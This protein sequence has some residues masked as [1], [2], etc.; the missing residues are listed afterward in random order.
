VK[1]I[2][3]KFLLILLTGLFVAAGSFYLLRR[4][5]ISRNAGGKLELARKRLDE[6]KVADATSLFAQY[7]ALR[8]RDNEAYAEYSKLLL[9]RALSPDATRNDVA[10]AFNTLEAAVR[11]NPDDDDLR[12]QLAEFQLRVGRGTDAREHLSLLEKRLAEPTPAGSDESPADRQARGRKVRF[13]NATTYL[14][15]G[16][17]EEAAR[18]V[19]EMVGYDLEKRQFRDAAEEVTA[20]TD[21]YVML[22]AILQERM[23]ARADARRVL[24]ELVRRHE[25]DPRAWLAMTSWFR[26]RGDLDQA[27]AAMAKALKLDPDAPECV[28][29]DFELAL[30]AR[31]L[32]RAEATVR[33]AVELFP[34][35]ERSY[36]GLAAVLMQQ[37]DVG[38]AEQALLDG[39]ERLPA[40]ASLQLMLADTLLQQNKLDE[41]AQAITRIRE[42][43]GS[44]SGP[45]GLLEARL[46]VA[47]RRWSEAKAKLEQMRPLLLGNAELVR[48]VDLYLAQ[49]HGQLNEYDAQLEVNRRI[50]TDEPGSL[51]ARA[52]A[53][54]ALVSAGKTAE[55]LEEFEAIASALPEDKLV[56]IP[57]VWYPLFQLRLA[58]QA[59][60]P[61]ADRDWSGVDA[62]L[63]SLAKFATVPPSQLA[64]LRAEALIR[65]GESQAARDLLE[66]TATADADVQVWAA[67]VT[68]AL[69]ADGPDA[70]TA[71]LASV[72]QRLTDDPALMA[73]EARIAASRPAEVARQ[74]L[75]DLEK[76]A[77]NLPS[78]EAAGV[79]VTIAPI[80]LAAGDRDAA[81]RLWEQAAAKAPDDLTIREAMLDTAV[82]MEDLERARAAA[83]AIA[84]IAGGTSA[85]SRVANANVTLLQ[86]RQRLAELAQ[87]G[88]SS[89]LD[90]PADVREL[91][92]GARNLLIEAESERRGWGQVQALFADVEVLRGNRP[93]AIDRLRRAVAAGPSNPA[94]VRRLVALLFAENRLKEAQ[95]AMAILGE[96]GLQGLERISAEVELRAGKFD[97]AVALAEQSV[98]GDTQSHEDLLWLGQLLARSGKLER[99]GEILERATTV[100]A[101]QPETWLALFNFRVATGGGQAALAPL[102]KGAAL[103]PEPRRQLTL[104]QGYQMLGQRE[105]SAELL[106]ETAGRWPDDLDVTRALA[107]DQVARGRRE[108]AR[109]LLGRILAADS[110]PTAV[111]S[112]AR[113]TLAELEASQGSYRD[114]QR[115][116]DLLKANRTTGDSVAPDDLALE[117]SLLANRPEPDSWRRAVKLLEELAEQKP[118]ST[119]ERLTRIQLQEKLGDWPAA[120]DE[121]VALVATPK[122]PPAYVALLIEKLI[123]HGEASTAK[124]WLRRLEKTAPNSP[125]TLALEAKLAIAENDRAKAVECARRLMPDGDAAVEKPAQL[126][127]VA[128][129]MEDLGFPKAADRLFERYAALDVAG[130]QAWVEFLGRQGRVDEALDLLES[131][132]DSLSLERAVSVAVQVLRSQGD[133]AAT[134]EAAGRIAPWIERAKRQDPGSVVVRLLEAELQALQDRN[135]E[136][137][138]IYRDLLADRSLKATEAAIVANNLAFQ[139]AKPDTAAEARKLI[140]TA[141]DQLGPLP[142]LLDTRGLVRLAQGD[143]AGAAADLREAIL[144]P[145][146]TKYLHLASAELAAG[147]TEAAR[148]ALASAR[149]AKL[150]AARLNRE[151]AARLETLERELGAA[152]AAGS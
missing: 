24:E 115:A 48:Q 53:A 152:A 72:P 93:A 63:D 148:A 30:A 136:A 36:R 5:Q 17:S 96:D 41:A 107:A 112:W 38:D 106:Q 91:L 151:D 50:L 147:N 123:A 77:A 66:K 141:I 114:L 146:A 92:D 69:R 130:I 59:G 79:F 83:T 116:I 128:K 135:A 99:A 12:L 49:C 18:I 62:L 32:D 143:H 71:A 57:Q 97:E 33:R 61:E 104:A 117:I 46:L 4:F 75:D 23:E 127:A 2:N 94:L 126:K 54:Q 134:A 35:D 13:L 86:A 10:R 105:K 55:A 139:L 108:E 78:A 51:A 40:K 85:R 52:G 6:G 119:G 1:R 64:L 98:A 144:D 122:A 84:K 37:G 81:A 76:R 87:A 9:G 19:A 101:D 8:P 102:Q 42:L 120:R 90:L 60:L 56:T 58:S 118:L 31:D 125:I 111:K 67:V 25:D 26:E 82:V 65:R 137:E 73:V 113:R 21:A 45:V 110:D 22:A 47:E 129:L 28:F 20:D 100:A 109:Q 103:M 121:L 27:A 131:K 74:A 95:D 68:L 133:E 16:E 89:G 29:A 70:A 124:I 149:A 88:Q 138:G 39:V 7:V 44:T 34:D 140:D 80:R 142:D 15:S 3:F 11:N 14:G 43:Y 132:W 150:A 145:S